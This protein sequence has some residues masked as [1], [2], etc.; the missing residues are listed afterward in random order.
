MVEHLKDG[1]RFFA[2]LALDFV[3]KGKLSLECPCLVVSTQ[4]C[5]VI[6]CYELHA[7]EVKGAF[8]RVIPTIDVVAKKG[9]ACRAE[10]NA[11]SPETLLVGEEITQIPVNVTYLR[12]A[13]RKLTLSSLMTGCLCKLTND[14]AGRVDFHHTRTSSQEFSHFFADEADVGQ[15]G[16]A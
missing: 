9:D 7:K 8:D 5:N 3:E 16:M 2:K 11:S 12:I 15:T 4:E 13:M 6:W 10:V 1:V 14:V